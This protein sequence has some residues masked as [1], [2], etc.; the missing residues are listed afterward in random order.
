MSSLPNLDHDAIV[1]DFQSQLKSCTQKEACPR[2][3][4]C[5]Q[6]GACGRDYIRFAK[7]SEWLQS[8]TATSPHVNQVDRLLEAAYREQN[9]PALPIS[10]SQICDENRC[11]LRVFCIL[12]KMNAGH[13]VHLLRRRNIV[14]SKLPIDLFS[15]HNSFDQLKEDSFRIWGSTEAKTLADLFNEYQWAFCPVKFDLLQDE[16]YDKNHVIPI[17]HKEII[18]DKGLTAS[19]WQIVVQEEFVGPSLREQTSHLKCPDPEDS[20]ASCYIFALKSFKEGYCELFENERSAFQVLKQHGGLVRYLSEYSHLA[21]SCSQPK[22]GRI[23]EEECTDDN[24][25][26]Y[27]IL[28]EYGEFDL[29]EYFVERLPPTNP[30]EIREFWTS[31]FAV[32]DAL[33]GIHTFENDRAG[34]RQ[35]YY[36]WHADIKPANILS[37][38]G[39]FKLADPGFAR[40]EKSSERDKTIISG[41]TT[42]YGAPECYR[43]GTMAPVHRAIDIWSLGCVFS[44]AATWVVLGDKGIPMFEELR[45]QAIMKIRVHLYSH[46]GARPVELAKGDY[47]HDG[48][49]VLEVVRL[50]HKYLGN[51]SRRTDTITAQVLDL[52]DTK[53]LCGK[54][55]QRIN[56]EEL[57]N[58]LGYI[59]DS[60]ASTTEAS[61]PENFTTALH[62]VD[63]IA[64]SK[65]VAS[66]SR[67]SRSEGGLSPSVGDRDGR[68]SKFLDLPLMKTAHRSQYQA[69]RLHASTGSDSNQD[70]LSRSTVD[71]QAATTGQPSPSTFV[72]YQYGQV[73]P[74]SSY[75]GPS[76]RHI[77]E[78]SDPSAGLLSLQSM[79][80]QTHSK[81]HSNQRKSEDVFQAHRA[82]HRRQ[83]SQ[84]FLGKV[85]KRTPRDEFLI[86]YF[87]NR[88]IKFLVDNASTM[89]QFW[90]EA[91]M[92]LEV[93][94][95][96]AKG[97]D[98]D[99]MDLSFTTGPV[100]IQNSNDERGFT[101]AMDNDDATPNDMTP[102]DMSASLGAILDA[103]LQD[104][105][106]KRLKGTRESKKR[107]STNSGDNDRK[108][109]VIVFTDGRWEGM[110]RKDQVDETIIDFSKA[111]AKEVGNL[112]KR[113]VSI[114]FVQ[115]GN[116]PD[117]SHR[118]R[119]LDNDLKYA[120]V[121]DIVDTEPSRG[122]VYK[123][124]LGSFVE[125][126]DKK[127]DEPEDPSPISPGSG[128]AIHESPPRLFQPGVNQPWPQI[129][130]P[131]PAELPS[132][133]HCPC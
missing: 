129:H 51:V 84:T 50:W 108:L 52:V 77:L 13:L 81:G 66:P 21:F 89:A 12:L 120:G 99:G 107:R 16:D 130:S 114:E 122:D 87:V 131:P 95:M 37:V 38:Q 25:T 116:D 18:N 36:G 97:L 76:S 58:L 35:E 64:I 117:A 2:K 83:K 75:S 48:Q 90:D 67:W 96:K 40:F 133:G 124:L 29:E 109:T 98:P 20:S 10:R 132:P 111:L 103:Y 15:L 93:L 54:A 123:M 24:K 7:L 113:Y 85:L 112:Q 3:E 30:N 19:L 1:R 55:A 71:M 8:T 65:P 6:K 119:H 126:F 82:L 72:A 57:C 62:E 88:D 61:L 53:M 63:R 45:R 44:I 127:N 5:M 110:D 70:V 74:N 80:S 102:T 32:A 94:T 39:N 128:A 9:A 73:L 27:N 26:T 47:F 115:F 92:L 69:T 14:D 34:V 42:S 60:S 46:P 17:Y 23:L 49:E 78:S 68:K 28:L 4:N 118:L 104:L 79:S 105:R 125:E 33:K 59:S 121:D 86:R 100:R 106:G 43:R 22:P 41:G 101:E 91:A 31:L 56:A 11:C